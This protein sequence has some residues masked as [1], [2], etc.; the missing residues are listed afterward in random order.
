MSRAAR[1][2]HRGD[3][4]Q[5]AVASHWLIRML[6]D[7]KIVSVQVDIIALPAS[8]D[9]AEVDDIV[10]TFDDQTTR[11]IQAKK[12]QKNHRPWKLTDS[13]LKEELVK[14]HRQLQKTPNATI[15]LCSH[16]PFGDL[17]TL[18]ESRRDYGNY[19]VFEAL[20]TSN[21]KEAFAKLK[22]ILSC[23]EEAAF[24]LL[25]HLEIGS[26]HSH[27]DWEAN[28]RSA[29]DWRVSDPEIAIDVIERMARENQTGLGLLP[30]PLDREK[31]LE[32]LKARN[33]FVF[34]N[35]FPLDQARIAE[36]FA[37]A[38]AELIQWKMTLPNNDWLERPELEVLQQRAATEPSSVT[39][40]LGD[41]G[42]G[43]SALLAKLA[44]DCAALGTPV[45]AI[46]ADYLTE[47]VRDSP[48]LGEY[49][50]LPADPVDCVLT[51]A[52][53]GKV[54]V[55]VDQ[56]DALADLV[57]LHS[58]RLR[59]PLELIHRLSGAPNVHIVASC[60]IFEH[61]HDTRLRNLEAE[62][63]MLDLPVWEKVEEVLKGYG[64]HAGGW[65]ASIR[66]G[67]RSPQSLNLF[68]QLIRT[69]SEAELLLG[70]QHMLGELWKQHVLSDTSGRSREVLFKISARMAE[71]E[72]LWL[73]EALFDAYHQELQRLSRLG[74][75]VCESG[76]VGFRHQ[77]LYEYIRARTFLEEPGLLADTVISRQQSLR[78]R[79]LLWHSFSYMR[80][81][82]RPSYV[83]EIERL[84]AAE[85]RPHLKMLLIEF[86]GQLQDPDLGEF[87]LVTRKWSESWYR[88]RF[89]VA[90]P[91]S[92]G[93]FDRLADSHLLEVMQLPLEQARM[94]LPA[95][96]GAM[97]TRQQ[98]V[99]QLV[100]SFWLHSS[101]LREL[102]WVVLG[103]IRSWSPQCVALCRQAIDLGRLPSW[104]V[105][106]MVGLVSA[107]LPSEAPSL[108]DAW[109]RQEV[110]QVE[111][112]VEAATVISALLKGRDFYDLPAVAEAA[113][114]AFLAAIWPWILMGLE[115][116]AM[117]RHEFVVGYRGVDTMFPD[118][119]DEDTRRES[120]IVASVAAAI[121]SLAKQDTGAFLEF[122][123]ANRQ[124]DLLPVQQL[125]ARGLSQIAAT[126]AGVVL[127][128]LLE[129]PRRLVVGGFQ[130][131]HASTKRLIGAV[132]PHLDK[133]QMLRLEQTIR[134][135]NRY[136][137]FPEDDAE[138]RL[139]RLQWTREHR[140]RLLRAIPNNLMSDN[141]RRHVAE[142]E[143]AFPGLHDR[144]V[145]LAGMREIRSP[146]SAANMQLADDADV[147]NLFAELTDETQWDH[148]RHRMQGGV[149]QAGRELAEVAKTSP[150]RAIGLIRRMMP[151]RNDVPV[152]AVF[153]A[154][155]ESK[156]DPSTLYALVSEFD[157]KGFKGEHFRT[158]A[159][160]AIGSV[161]SAEIPLPQTQ[162]EL[163]NSWLDNAVI[164]L[165][166]VDAEKEEREDSATSIIW[167][168]GGF[169]IV[170]HGTYSFLSALTF[171]CLRAD[172]PKTETWLSALE[173]H[174][175]RKERLSVWTSMSHYLQWLTYA[176]RTRAQNFFAA[177]MEAYP[178]LL[179]KRPGVMLFAHSQ[180]WTEA[181][182]A[183]VLIHRLVEMSS[184][185][186]RQAAGEVLMLR[187]ALHGGSEGPVD[188]VLEQHLVDADEDA[189]A[190][191]VCV[192]IA[193]TAAELWHESRFR[194]LIHPH[195]LRLF[196]LK[197]Q[198]V[199]DAAV[200][201]FAKRELKPDR[202]SREL[203][204]LLK[205]H[206][207]LLRQMGANDFGDCL[208]SMLE[209]EPAL[210]ADLACAL[211]DAVGD[212]FL[213]PTASRY[214]LTDSLLTISLR[215]QEMGA[216]YQE[217]GIQI[218][219]RILE[220]NS[221][222]ARSVML[223]LDK[224][225][226]NVAGYQPA[227]RRRR[228]G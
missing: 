126:H 161:V 58:S 214:F 209:A 159:A 118:I 154:L 88:N 152:G 35:P 79:P 219:E 36:A 199:R 135:W 100:G 220:L 72:M 188:E 64:V 190:T 68:L 15:E 163:L 197:D 50:H 189:A 180:N 110:A 5:I 74:I 28:N 182:M 11:H 9:A 59:A 149:I 91:G 80:S 25:R 206:P 34:S 157:Q 83:K 186:S 14:A 29:L 228:K 167:S 165:D 22:E 223:D 7:P 82:D 215:L 81:V 6:F 24:D 1:L 30:S 139:R 216:P 117:E 45:L 208:E 184:G 10:I 84:W 177:L 119:E 13:N 134:A 213:S 153:R 109:I 129:D 63:M 2:S 55:L 112:P 195:L 94:A 19:A 170:P 115:H 218:F 40:V 56:L 62:S 51:L 113:P 168:H 196:F 77:T 85:L 158:G 204:E 150:E 101:E 16:T 217:A 185:F 175:R 78:V 105:D 225:T 145:W 121:K 20:A 227:R 198:K 173:A 205:A 191:Q 33:V 73:P 122:L 178:G 26:A 212:E 179:Q 60:R 130:D 32:A 42:S 211:Q 127:D 106:H 138:T 203:L 140:L 181:E 27:S 194:S 133:G 183:L 156:Y 87:T 48:S 75:L 97:P 146:M 95:L 123:Q 76:R 162:L 155:G 187:F 92:V 144:D 4:Y 222:E 86:L 39:L 43:K 200:R 131:S 176:D 89:L 160:D 41:P 226:V 136:I 21:L 172:P 151:D 107:A 54:L 90:F 47:E 202:F 93:W 31:I 70:Y 210:V 108:V 128:F 38:S 143:R 114:S 3:A 104:Q 37:I 166:A 224:R 193:Y 171:A 96:C 164:D 137:F 46:K 71:R 120:P 49:L 17:A 66:E 116:H 174:L 8:L 111:P 67:L 102:A 201:V 53:Q 103:N 148:P 141:C 125:L 207:D 23:T 57:V 192:G 61:R 99:L 52:K 132:S 147:L 44:R 18:V 169:A 69:T 65:N 12:N 124:L 221:S 98:Q 142:E